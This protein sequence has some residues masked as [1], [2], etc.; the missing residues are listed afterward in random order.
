M[1]TVLD[2]VA[3]ALVLAGSAL[4]MIAGLGLVRFPDVL[5]RLHAGT[6]PQVA[7]LLLV[8][9]GAVLRLIGEPVVWMLVLAGFLQLLTVP[10]SAHM[11]SRIAY[12]RRHLRR[13][14]LIVDDVGPPRRRDPEAPRGDEPADAPQPAEQ[15]SPGQPS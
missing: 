7:G 4:A 3:V 6:K 11:V 5:T 8:L 2:A 12:R 9:T 10:L 15:R 13:D 1:Q 14:L